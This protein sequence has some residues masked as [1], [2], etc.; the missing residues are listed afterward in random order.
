MDSR[1]RS[2]YHEYVGT[3]FV[4]TLLRYTTQEF[5][6][7]SVTKVVGETCTY[8]TISET[9]RKEFFHYEYLNASGLKKYLTPWAEKTLL[10]NDVFSG[11]FRQ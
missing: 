10:T 9:T 11:I 7:Q 1:D 5:D 8:R 6:T 2:M 3:G 4:Y